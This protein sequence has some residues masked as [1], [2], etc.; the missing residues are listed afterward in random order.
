MDQFAGTTAVLAGLAV[1]GMC[2]IARQ[3]WDVSKSRYFWVAFVALV[4]V[5]AV[6]I[7]Y[8]SNSP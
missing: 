2:A 3:N 1:A 5:F 7:L 4:G 6:S 8:L